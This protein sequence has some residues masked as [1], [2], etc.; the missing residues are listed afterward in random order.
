MYIPA[1]FEESRP[2]ELQR[3]L[4]EHPLGA[5]V[6]RGPNG[7]DANHILKVGIESRQL[8]CIP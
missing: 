6:T 1:P 3:V 8:K 5:L 2:G 4:R 7:L